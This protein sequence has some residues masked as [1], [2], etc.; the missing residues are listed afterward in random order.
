MFLVVTN[1]CFVLCF[2]DM[3]EICML[4][5]ISAVDMLKLNSSINSQDVQVIFTHGI[6]T[7]IKMMLTVN[8][9]YKM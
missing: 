1:R 8:K 5:F 4:S 7:A 3:N 2:T 9:A 6:G